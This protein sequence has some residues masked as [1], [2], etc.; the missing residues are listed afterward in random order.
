MFFKFLQYLKQI[1][2][3]L[4]RPREK[5]IAVLDP[6][7]S[8]HLKKILFNF[9]FVVINTR[10][11]EIN[12]YV[13]FLTLIKFKFSKELTFYQNY[14]VNNLKIINPKIIITCTTHNIFFLNIKKFFPNTKIVIIQHATLSLH[15][16]KDI[17]N[18][19][20]VKNIPEKFNIDYV[21]IFGSNSKKFF[22]QFINTKNYILTGSTKNN[23]F[24]DEKESRN[25]IILISQVRF[26]KNK[27][28]KI[29]TKPYE[30]FF[31]ENI[32][33]F[34]AYHKKKLYVL[35]SRPEDI[36]REK[37]FYDK[38]IGNKHYKFLKNYNWSSS[39]LSA[40][41]FKF[42]VTHSST[43]GSELMAR[44]K[45]VA[46]FH[47]YEKR[48]NFT[49]KYLKKIKTPRGYFQSFYTKK[50]NGKFWSNTKDKRE[51]K[52]ILEYSYFCN[53]KVFLQNKKKY[54][55]PFIIYNKNNIIFKNLIQKIYRRKS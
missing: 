22:S 55:D 44:G 31:Y 9:E 41:K 35:S 46:F 21:C 2:I 43:L 20:A 51:F 1:K 19:K 6:V 23:H 34:C 28:R 3:S 27:I 40:M 38:I 25:A 33:E 50:F 47:E 48:V 49:K 36:S 32:K 7:T 14:L 45:R 13:L 12:L 10:Y 42:F 53:E 29:L 16:L 52:D 54:I 17:L 37:N 30:K 39:Y 11:E 15:V 24:K 4:S 18:N 5:K 26:V 8:I